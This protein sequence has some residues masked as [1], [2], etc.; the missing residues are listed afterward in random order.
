MDA[1]KDNWKKNLSNLKERLEKSYE[2]KTMVQEESRLIDGLVRKKKGYVIFSDYRRN[3]GKRRFQDVKDEIDTALVEIDCCDS[4]EAM[5]VYLETLKSVVKQTRW[6]KILET[7]S[8]Y[9][10]STD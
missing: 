5:L 9:T 2:Y 6:A 4:K 7:L 1:K 8:S 10:H 3:D